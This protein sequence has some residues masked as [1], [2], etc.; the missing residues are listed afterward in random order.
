MFVGL[1]YVLGLED[2]AV[3]L[4]FRVFRLTFAL[5]SLSFTLSLLLSLFYSLSLSL[6]LSLFFFTQLRTKFESRDAPTLCGAAFAAACLHRYARSRAATDPFMPFTLAN[7]HNLAQVRASPRE[8]E[9]S[10]SHHRQMIIE[11]FFNSSFGIHHK[12]RVR[13]GGRV[14]TIVCG[15]FLTIP[16]FTFSHRHIIHTVPWKCVGLILFRSATRA[17]C[18]SGCC[19]R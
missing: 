12:K 2:S 15:Q 11:M 10:D 16:P 9:E 19:T 6:T 18:V 8:R 4:C 13:S 17:P 5:L 3:S 1:L 14:C 7:L